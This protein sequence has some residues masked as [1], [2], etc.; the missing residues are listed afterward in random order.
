MRTWIVTMCLAFTASASAQDVSFPWQARLLG[1]DGTPI[2]G[3]LDLT[4]ELFDSEADV[5]ADWSDS[6]SV[7]ADDGY[8]AVTLGS[9][10]PIP[11]D[12][13]STGSLWSRVTLTDSGAELSPRLPV[14]MTPFSARSAAIPVS[15]SAP[16]GACVG[17]TGAITFDSTQGQ[18]LVCDGA[19]WQSVSPQSTT[20]AG[21]VISFAGTTTPDGYLYCDGSPVSRTTYADL[22]AALGTSF[23]AGDGATTFNLPDLRGRFVRGQDDGTGRDP[24][25]SSRVAIQSG[26]NTGDA[27]GTLQSG[28]IQ[29]HQHSTSIGANH[30]DYGDGQGYG[31]INN[32][33]WALHASW[34][35]NAT[36]GSET[37]PVNVA[38]RYYV[39]H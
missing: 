37:R 10:L 24:D 5:T 12:L 23:G 25:A 11:L 2:Q 27:V 38:L 15:T 16:T 6:F 17:Q 31:L 3:E 34:T 14:S 19:T 22:F 8:V 29:S 32:N 4:I 30:A 18:L 39:K 36:G 20:P 35:S 33:A 7:D 28:Q 9:D 26:G 21:T 13:L 1:A